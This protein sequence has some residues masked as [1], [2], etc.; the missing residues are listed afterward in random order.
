VTDIE[1][2]YVRVMVLW[3]VVLAGLWWLERAFT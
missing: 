1:R 2:S 3:V